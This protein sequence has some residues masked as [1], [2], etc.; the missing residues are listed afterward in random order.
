M[1]PCAGPRVANRRPGV[2]ARDA[3][4]R[5]CWTRRCPVPERASPG[6][7]PGTSWRSLARPPSNRQVSAVRLNGE[8]GP[9]PTEI[10]RETGRR[11][12]RLIAQTGDDVRRTRLDAGVTVATL[13]RATGIDAAHLVRIEAGDAHPSNEALIAIGVALGA[14]LSLRFF[15]GS[16]PRIHDRFQ[17]PMVEALLRILDLRWRVELE[18]PITRPARGVIDLVLHDSH[19]QQRLR[20]SSTP[21]SADSSSR[22]AGAMRRPTGCRNGWPIRSRG[23]R[24][25]A[26]RVC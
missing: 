6:T 16:G 7:S 25:A 15:P 24:P 26:C 21:T 20:P 5:D 11:L 13:A 8:M 18:V 12:R 1:D 22:F 10:R 23:K 4:F 9:T 3:G 2:G 14:D 17:A 19:R